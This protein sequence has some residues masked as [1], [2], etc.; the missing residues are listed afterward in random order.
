M[1]TDTD[2][3]DQRHRYECEPCGIEGPLRD[4][5][6]QAARD[7]VLDQIDEYQYVSDPLR[8]KIRERVEDQVESNI[9][10]RAEVSR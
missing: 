9:D 10:K 6:D 2:E 3:T 4:T 1:T 7:A 5:R 8:S